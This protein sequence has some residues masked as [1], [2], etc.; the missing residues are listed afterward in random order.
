[1]ILY[2]PFTSHP[3]GIPDG[4]VNVG[5]DVISIKQRSV[6]RQSFAEGITTVNIQ[7]FLII[8]PRSSKFQKI[9]KF[10]SLCHIAVRVEAHKAQTGLAQVTTAKISDMS[11]LTASNVPIVCGVGAVTCARSTQKLAMLQLQVSGR[12]GT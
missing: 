12:R 1:V 8:L 7:F 3:E 2:L 11:G 10:M 9:F 5:F 6:T 4:L